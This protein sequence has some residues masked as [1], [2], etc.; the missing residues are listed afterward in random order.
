MRR[1]HGFTMVELITVMILVGVLAAIAIPRMLGDNATDA[2]V[3]GD[4]VA[5]ALRTA[6]KAAVARR[7]TVCATT[8]TSGVQLRI[9]QAPGSASCEASFDDIQDNAYDS[10]SANVTLQ[11]GAPQLFF[12]PDGSI[13]ASAAGAPLALHTITIQSSGVTTRSIALHGR[14]GLVL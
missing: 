12:R 13:A 10:R 6:Q 3:F 11:N 7:R 8:S 9:S 14:T 1:Q 2:T 5:S 4:Q